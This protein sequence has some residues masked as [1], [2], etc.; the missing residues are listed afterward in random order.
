MV[1][2]LHSFRIKYHLVSNHT[3]F[4]SG[5]PTLL[6]DL[7]NNLLVLQIKKEKVVCPEYHARLRKKGWWVW[8]S[9]GNVCIVL[10]IKL[11]QRKE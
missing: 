6:G 8:G 1:A 10:E 2:T 4:A 11:L 5:I 9:D 3:F 7:L